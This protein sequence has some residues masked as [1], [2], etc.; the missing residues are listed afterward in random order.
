MSENNYSKNFQ[1]N[2]VNNP[3]EPDATENSNC[4]SCERPQCSCGNNEEYIKKLVDCITQEVLNKLG[5]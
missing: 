3:K 2:P 5:N 4:F 1:F